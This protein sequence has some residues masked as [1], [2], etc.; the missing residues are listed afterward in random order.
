MTQQNNK[1]LNARILIVDDKPD[2]VELLEMML[3]TAGYINITTTTDPTKVMDLYRKWRYD[4]ILLDLRMPVMDGFQVMKELSSVITDDYLPI[5]VL[6]AEKETEVRHQALESGAKDFLS[7]P[8]DNTEVLNRIANM[9]DVRAHYNE[10][11]WQAEIVEAE[12]RRRTQEIQETRL[13]VI[14]TL[15]RAAEFRD[16][17]TGMH[18]IRMSIFCKSLALAAGLGEERAELIL[19]AS[20]MHDVGKIGIPDRV[21]LKAGKL[22]DEEFTLMQSHTEIGAEIIGEHHTELMQ[23]ARLIAETHHEKW[24]GTGYPKGLKGDGISIEG[25]IC[26]ISDVFDALTSERPYKQPWPTKEAAQYINDNAGVF[27]DP[28]LVKVFNEILPEWLE[29]QEQFPDKK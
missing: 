23:L 25:R 11:R 22:D 20:P 8:F 19:N 15:G 17:E 1:N 10:R 24:D 5:L 21:L 14:R 12:V 13:E 18:V 28:D 6:T 9:L 26:A 4:I 16:N 7:K 29:I 27:F 3:M 2:N